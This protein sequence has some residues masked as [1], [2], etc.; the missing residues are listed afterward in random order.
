[1][2]TIALE[3]DC[4]TY[5]EY[6]RWEKALHAKAEP[7]HDLMNVLRT[8]KTEAELER[9]IQAQRIAEKAFEEI[10]NDIRP[11]VTHQLLYQT[12]KLFLRELLL[13]P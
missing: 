13:P 12:K 3:D 9:I 1:M 4:L 5:Q 2:R 11:G 6:C 8:V 10:L 7:Q